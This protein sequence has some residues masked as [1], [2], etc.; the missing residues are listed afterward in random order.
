M[1]PPTEVF[2]LVSIMEPNDPLAPTPRIAMYPVMGHN[3]IRCRQ[4]T[5]SPFREESKKSPVRVPSSMRPPL[6][7]TNWPLCQS[8]R[9]RRPLRECLRRVV[10]LGCFI[11]K[12]R[13]GLS[14]PTNS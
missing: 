12:N 10:P 5:R 7:R 2:A 11:L 1:L 4:K 13:H 8:R 14:R 9:L 3:R 6:R